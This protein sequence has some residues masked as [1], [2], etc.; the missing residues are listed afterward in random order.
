MNNMEVKNKQKSEEQKN[1]LSSE[2][3]DVVSKVLTFVDY[4]DKQ[5]NN[6]RKGDKK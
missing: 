5:K 4:A 2:F 1:T 6:K 3:F